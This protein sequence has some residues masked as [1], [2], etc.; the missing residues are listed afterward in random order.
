MKNNES[1]MYIKERKERKKKVCCTTIM[2]NKTIDMRF[3]IEKK[4]YVISVMLFLLSFVFWITR[5]IRVKKEEASN[6]IFYVKWNCPYNYLNSIK[7]VSIININIISW[8]S[9]NNKRHFYLCV[10]S[11]QLYYYRYNNH[12]IDIINRIYWCIS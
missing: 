11:F 3:L 10:N 12:K 6:T 5:E 1:H 9:Q 4:A 7:S 8:S 2:R